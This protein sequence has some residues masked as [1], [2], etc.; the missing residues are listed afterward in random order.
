MYT[1]IAHQRRKKSIC[2]NHVCLPQ[3]DTHLFAVLAALALDGRIMC[4]IDDEQTV[5][6]T[7]GIAAQCGQC[8]IMRRPENGSRKILLPPWKKKTEVENLNAQRTGRRV[9]VTP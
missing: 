8:Y 9:L 7:T 3:R 2:K 4:Q 6:V 1:A 5:V